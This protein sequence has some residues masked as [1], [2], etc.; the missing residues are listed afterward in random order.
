MHLVRLPACVLTT[1]EKDS[2]RTATPVQA[3]NDVEKRTLTANS[4]DLAESNATVLAATADAES[5]KGDYKATSLAPSASWNTN[6]NTG[7]FTWS[8][9]MPTPQVPGGLVPDVSLS[10][11]SGTI[12]GRTS[13]TNNQ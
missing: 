5:D 12:D 6:L 13:S 11:S 3:S 4:V 9:D 1:P 7:D 2:C 10:Y 8:Y